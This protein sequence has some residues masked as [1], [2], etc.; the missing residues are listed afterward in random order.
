MNQFDT[1]PER[2]LDLGCGGGL[3]VIDTARQWQAGLHSL[4]IAPFINCL[5]QTSTFIGFDVK[6]IQPKLQDLDPYKDIARRVQWVHGNL[7][8][9]AKFR[10]CHYL[11]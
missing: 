10:P 2:T 8:V 5:Y 11:I 3:W 1:P 7:Y 9:W 6:D 4:V